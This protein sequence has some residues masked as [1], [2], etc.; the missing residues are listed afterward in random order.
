VLPRAGDGA[1]GPLADV[2]KFLISGADL[3]YKPEAPKDLKA[4]VPPELYGAGGIV[5]REVPA[6]DVELTWKYPAISTRKY[7]IER[8]F[9]ADDAFEKIAE[10]ERTINKYRDEKVPLGAS[11]TYQLVACN[12][13]GETPSEANVTTPKP[14]S[15]VPGD[16]EGGDKDWDLKGGAAA[17]SVVR[18]GKK[19]LNITGTGGAQKSFETKPNK[20]YVVNGYVKVA[21]QSAESWGGV[22]AAVADGANDKQLGESQL[23]ALKK[24]H[25]FQREVKADEWALFQFTFTAQSNQA[26]ITLETLA[27]AGVTIDAAIDDL[28]I[29][30]Q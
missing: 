2:L 23:F 22:R 8:K 20:I 29:K 13:A 24:R 25:P 1:A 26:R 4:T 5:S 27:P 9:G 3:Y 30:E 11:V 16:F 18:S 17:G 28:V 7:R 19:A 10:P 6:V 15:L 21:K 12:S 14:K